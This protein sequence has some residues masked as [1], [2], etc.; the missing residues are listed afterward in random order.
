MPRSKAGHFASFVDLGEAG[1]FH[2]FPLKTKLKFSLAA[3][4]KL[5][6]MLG[7]TQKEI[8]DFAAQVIGFYLAEDGKGDVAGMDGVI[9]F[10][11]S[12]PDNLDIAAAVATFAQRMKPHFPDISEGYRLWLIEEAQTNHWAYSIGVILFGE[13][14]FKQWV[15]K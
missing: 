9:G 12:N 8:D 13:M 7:Y 10:Y 4:A 1:I 11:L 14:T 3:A 15:N 5:A 2:P 6:Q